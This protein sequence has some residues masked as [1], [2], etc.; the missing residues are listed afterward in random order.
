MGYLVLNFQCLSIKI[1]HFIHFWSKYDLQMFEIF[2]NLVK[3]CTWNAYKKKKKKN[4]T[5]FE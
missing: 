4:G 3:I 1:E 2:T 5:L